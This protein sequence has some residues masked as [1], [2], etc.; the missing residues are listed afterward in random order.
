MIDNHHN[1]AS[2][3]PFAAAL[4]TKP[5]TDRP[6]LTRM[7]EQG[8]LAAIAAALAIYANDKAQDEQLSALRREI[9]ELKAD[10]R[11]ALSELRQDLAARR[12]ESPSTKT[13]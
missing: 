12:T 10:T 11:A 2:C 7:L 6:L 13:K 4:M 3:V 8:A 9:S 5:P 1:I